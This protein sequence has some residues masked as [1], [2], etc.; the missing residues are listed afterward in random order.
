[1]G[2]HY[3]ADIFGGAILGI[4]SAYIVYFAFNFIEGRFNKK[5]LL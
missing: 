2:V 5:E 4:F 1:L 3:P